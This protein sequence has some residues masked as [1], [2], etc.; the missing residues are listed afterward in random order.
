MGLPEWVKAALF[1]AIIV[2][3]GVGLLLGAQALRPQPPVLN[4]G[5]AV[6][7]TIE[8]AGWTIRYASNDT[9]NGTVFLF[10][11]EAAQTLHFSV[12]WSNWSPPYSAVFVDAINGARNNDGGN[13]RW[14]V[15]WV[16]GAY[17]TTAAD[18]TVLHG[19]EHIAWRYTTPEGG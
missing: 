2:V 18:L 5:I 13:G 16:D 10:L 4:D 6:S 12:E 17:A 14:W 7:L 15:F 8:G 19:G 11:L 9:R 3:S 1:A